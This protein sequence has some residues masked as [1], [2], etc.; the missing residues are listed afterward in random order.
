MTTKCLDHIIVSTILI[1]L[2]GGLRVRAGRV[3]REKIFIYF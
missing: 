3:K 2:I 1:I